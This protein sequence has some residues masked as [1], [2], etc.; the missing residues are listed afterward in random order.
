M[1]VLITN[2]GRLFTATEVGV[3]S[4]AAVVVEDG[5][6][7]WVGPAGKAPGG[8]DE[9]VD[10]EGALVT[11]GLI[12]AHTHP[13]YAG[14]RFDEIARRSSGA[15]Y[16]EIAAAGGGIR[17]TVAATRA[18]GEAELT[19]LVRARLARWLAGG[20]TTVEAKTGYHL[21]RSG[22]L[23]AVRLLAA[24]AHEA[25]TP[26]ALGRS[27][28]PNTG[29]RREDRTTPEHPG[30]PADSSPADPGARPGL[31]DGDSSGA[32]AGRGDRAVAGAAGAEAVDLPVDP[33][34][35]RSVS[36]GGP[37]GA[38]GDLR[39]PAVDGGV[40][41]GAAG[42]GEGL[43]RIEVT[44]LGAHDVGEPGV[45]YDAWA[46]EVAG[47][48]GE[49]AGGARF[50]DVF[51]DAG[52]FSVEQARRVLVAGRGAGLLLRI[53]ADELERTGGSLLAAELG[54]VSAD[55]L[56]CVVD[57]D[58]RALSTAGVVATLCPITALALRRTPPARLLAE[59][60]VTLALG[61][62]HNPGQSGTTSMSLV[63][64]LAVHVLGLSVAEALT[65]ATAGGARSLA[66]ADRGVIRPGAL[67]DLVAWDADHE[68]AFAWE[69]GLRPR[70]VWKGGRPPPSPGDSLGQGPRPCAGGSGVGLD[71]L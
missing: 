12:D 52:Y 71:C 68:A 19:R 13:V 2:I 3:V 30:P 64:G 42:E 4:G 10:G 70:R 53:H 17:A 65:A 32:G 62:D 44:F 48:S 63:V 51:C 11:P 58:A 28:P 59:H 38:G 9:R 67:A 20:T 60:G 16:Q 45:G 61:S 29:D 14:D 57:D 24:L 41:G 1:R 40:G 18:A 37:A 27:D 6:I 8:W 31:S 49:A 33:G 35:G 56:L 54:A 25:D 22:E 15:G 46:D 55:H 43:P 50:V 21:D 47:W 34:A 23:T 36:A 69:L 66:F 5:R 26:P 39:D 7:A